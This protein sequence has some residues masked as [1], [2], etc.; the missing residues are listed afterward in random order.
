[1][2]SHPK[3]YIALSVILLTMV[4]GASVWAAPSQQGLAPLPGPATGFP[5]PALADRDGNGLS[6]DLQVKLAEAQ[7]GDRFKVIVS[8]FGS[9]SSAAAQQS[10]GHFVV[11]REFHIIRGFAATMTA[12]QVRA[13]SQVAGVARIEPDSEVRAYLETARSDFGVDQVV[14]NDLNL[15]F[16]G[17]GVGICVIDTGVDPTHEQLD[18]GKVVAFQDYVKYQVLAYDDHGHGTHVASIAAGDGAGGSEAATY[19]GVAPDAVVYA[20]KVLDQAGNGFASVI[21]AG[22]EWCS[23]QPD[24]DVL[25]LSLGSLNTSD[26][27]DAMSTAAN[28]VAD[29]SWVNPSTNVPCPDPTLLPKVVVLSAGNGGPGQYQIS[30]PAAAEK[31][32]T[33]GAVADLGEGGIYRPVFSSPGPTTDDRIK[34]DIMAPGVAITAA[35]F[36][37]FNFYVPKSGTSMSSPF[38]AGTVALALQANSGLTPTQVK[39]ELM[40]TAQDWGPAGKDIDW[41]WGLLDAYAFVGSVAGVA[42]TPT[43]F[44]T[45]IRIDDI[46]PDFSERTYEFDVTDPDK[47]IAVT[48]TNG[49]PWVCVWLN[50]FGGLSCFATGTGS[51]L[52]AE[53]Y[54]PSNTLVDKSTCEVDDD[55][56]CGGIA[57]Q[58]TLFAGPPVQTGTWSVR[59]Y[60]WNGDAFD[61]EPES[62]VGVDISYFG[63]EPGTE[64]PAPEPPPVAKAGVEDSMVTGR[65]ET[66]GKG[67]NKTTTYVL[68]DSFTAGDDVIIKARVV[69]DSANSVVGATVDIAITGPTP[70]NLTTGPSDSFGVAEA[71]WQTSDGT[72]A[73]DYVATTKDVNAGV[74]YAWDGFEMSTPTFNLAS[75][76]GGSKGGGK[77][78]PKPKKNTK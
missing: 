1:M 17:Q 16:T 45:H 31:A 75:S 12:A 13:L 5:P 41:G 77:G 40:N 74:G 51:D 21:I 29:P 57:R 34:P 25:N 55:T 36:G 53:L 4:I 24:V 27:T 52:D 50:L 9:G 11:H 58:E 67:R 66:T 15:G 70:V 73:G 39:N 46:I 54:D 43:A 69:D 37:T 44:P 42:V 78:G 71:R 68:T 48:I 32:I 38:V 62:S 35:D 47:P 14:V 7:P 64:P 2:S 59:V 19:R 30:S 76:G 60:P 22:I 72:E 20:A 18:N 8:L 3:R 56:D 10:V 6:D 26:G 49:G 33:V 63:S 23:G 65:Y 28:C 61:S